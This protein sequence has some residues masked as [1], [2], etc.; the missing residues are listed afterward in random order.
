M[1]VL[2]CGSRYFQDYELL[3]GI[4]SDCRISRIIH[5]AAK[6]ADNLAGQFG[7]EMGIPV[8]EY[9]ADWN[10]YGRRA[11]PIRNSQM[12]RDGL[13]ELVIAFRG[14][15]SRGTQD[16]INKSRKAGIPVKVVDIDS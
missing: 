6:G 2:V 3:K 10:Q 1:K 5:G 13:P 15:N 7:R 4:L 14:P 12:L 8:D 11:G 9:P 16:M